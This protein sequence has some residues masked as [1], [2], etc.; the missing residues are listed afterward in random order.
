LRE[1]SVFSDIVAG[2]GRVIQILTYIRKPVEIVGSF[3]ITVSDHLGLIID[4]LEELR[5][6]QD[7]M[8]G[9]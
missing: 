7:V 5:Y 6:N 1:K 9:K 4:Y 2:M 8:D 3:L